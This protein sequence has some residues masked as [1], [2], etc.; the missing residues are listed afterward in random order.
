MIILEEFI[1]IEILLRNIMFKLTLIWVGEVNFSTPP[2][3]LHIAPP[4]L[5]CWFNF[6]NSETVKAVTLTFCT[7][8]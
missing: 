5:H 1:F 7:I 8:Q 3:P 4:S 2:L 6:N